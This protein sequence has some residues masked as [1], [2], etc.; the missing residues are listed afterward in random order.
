[1]SDEFYMRP[2]LRV[3]DVEASVAYYC[4]KLGFTRSWHHGPD[5][6][7]IAQVGRGGLDIILDAGS[8]LPKPATPTVLSM[9]LHAGD[10]LGALHREF[11]ER[12]AKVLSAPF[13]GALAEGRLPVRRRRPR[14]QRARVL[15]RRTDV[16]MAAEERPNADVAARVAGRWWGAPPTSLRRFETGSGHWVYDVAGADGQ[17]VVVKLG[18]GSQRENFTGAVHWSRTLRPLGV[19]LPALLD[20]GELDG[21]RYLVLERLLGVDLGAAYPSLSS[22]QKDALAR[23]ISRIQRLVMSMPEG[24]GYGYVTSPGSPTRASW[25]AVLEDSFERSRARIEQARLFDAGVVQKVRA[26]A[27]RF[28]T[29][30]AAV[31]ARPF[32]DDTTTKNV[33]VHEGALS[34]IVDVDWICYGDPLLTIGLTRT[35][36]LSAGRDAEYVEYWCRHA[37]V[38]A[39]Q[40]RVLRF[41]TALYC[42]DFLSEFGQAFNRKATAPDPALVSRLERL[43]DA[44]LAAL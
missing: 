16:A 24:D 6:T 17:H 1:V 29:Y 39:E 43:L 38:T 5:K 4:D 11:S 8:V 36:L 18:T 13:G 14:R 23:E 19:P 27:Q 15:G 12:G 40:R 35:A 31:R 9:S 34:G 28:E 3:A 41:Y 32:L 2:L 26:F 10:Q 37:D 42:L 22:A 21:F 7:L 25:R 30:F 20:S 44:E 33:L